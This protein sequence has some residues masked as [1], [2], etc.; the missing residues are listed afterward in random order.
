MLRAYQQPAATPETTAGAAKERSAMN[1]KQISVALENTSGKLFEL[2]EVLHGADVDIRSL[3]VSEDSEFSTVHLI[4]DKPDL[5]FNKLLSK[6]Y[7]AKI[8]DVFALKAEDKPGGLMKI[9]KKLK[10]INLN[11]EYVYGFGEKSENKAVFIFRITEIDRAI[12]ALKAGHIDYVSRDRVEGRG[13]YS[14][15]ELIDSF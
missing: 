3:W 9:L 5:A 6:G 7:L 15:W 14:S 11:I 8:V 2:T 13:S 4:V 1:I 12:E 10:E